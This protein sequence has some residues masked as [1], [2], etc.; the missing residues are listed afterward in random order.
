[1]WL[2]IQLQRLKAFGIS[3][4]KKELYSRK[5]QHQIGTGPVEVFFKKAK[6]FSNVTV[7][8]FLGS[9]PDACEEFQNHCQIECNCFRAILVKIHVLNIF[10]PHLSIPV[11]KLVEAQ[12]H[13]PRHFLGLKMLLE[14]F[15]GKRLLFIVYDFRKFCRGF[16]FY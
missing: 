12:L 16:C 2:P 3:M 15:P 7:G 11:S 9:L 6:G 1:M 13:L 10:P 14:V 4:I 8:N 5:D